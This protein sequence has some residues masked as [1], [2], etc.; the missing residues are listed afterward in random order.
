MADSACMGVSSIKSVPV[1]DCFFCGLVP[2]W[3]N[4][5]EL[6]TV[7]LRLPLMSEFRSTLIEICVADFLALMRR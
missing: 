6:L 1:A 2:P 4:R 7:L 5:F 3:G